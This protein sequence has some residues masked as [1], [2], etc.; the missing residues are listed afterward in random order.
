MPV[1]KFG[2]MSDSKTKDT[3]VSLTYI[4][5]NYIRSDGGTPVTGSIDMRGNTLHNVA[6]PKK[7]Q[8]VATK[9]YADYIKLSSGGYI[10][11]KISD[12]NAKV[13][14]LLERFTVIQREVIEKLDITKVIRKN[15]IMVNGSY[16]GPLRRNHFQFSFGGNNNLGFVVPHSGIIK[17]MKMKTPIN[18]DN[19]EYEASHGRL[20]LSDY[21]RT[22]FFSFTKAKEATYLTP[23]VIG[24]IRCIRAYKREVRVGKGFLLEYDFCF[25]DYLPIPPENVW[26]EE[27]DIIN[28]KSEIDLDFRPYSEWDK[29]GNLVKLSEH[30]YLVSFLIELDPL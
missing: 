13:S 23:K 27:G 3:G 14:N 21:E 1:D 8:D 25:D 30:T 15:I 28:I 24:E 26:V 19:F 5:N 6:E 4:N 20:S 9:D 11:R 10:N 18:R 16:T 17:K 7:S 12:F 2:R 29:D 22:P